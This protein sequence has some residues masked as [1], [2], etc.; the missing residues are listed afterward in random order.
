MPLKNI[1]A[2]Q[3]K[4]CLEI[5]WEAQTRNW[6]NVNTLE[7]AREHFSANIFINIKNFEHSFNWEIVKGVDTSLFGS[8]VSETGAIAIYCLLEE[9]ETFIQNG[10]I[11]GTLYSL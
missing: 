9:S 11:Y 10:G 4:I 5:Q 2:S 1:T 7:K 3:A 6:C 8:L